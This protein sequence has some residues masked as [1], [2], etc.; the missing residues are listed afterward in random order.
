MFRIEE[1]VRDFLE[2]AMTTSL[3]K[4]YVGKVPPNKIPVNQL[5]ALCVYGTKTTLLSDQLTTARD[6]YS[7]DLSIDV[8]TNVY[9]KVSGT[10]IE[11]DDILLAQ[12]TLKQLIEERD[13]DMKPIATSVLGAL[14]GNIQG[15]FYLYHR[16]LEINYTNQNIDGQLY[17][18]GTLT[19]KGIQRY[20]N[21]T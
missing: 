9:A 2:T 17:F 15:D 19:L 20:N 12:K 7:F 1:E 5:P 11:S 6:K 13:S 8:I 16:D 14:R 4:Y 18:V 3:K 10:G 21:R